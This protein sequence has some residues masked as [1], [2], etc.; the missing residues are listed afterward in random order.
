MAAAV[1]LWVPYQSETTIPS[2]PHSPFSNSPSSHGCSLQYVPFSL[3]YADITDHAPASSTAASNGT[4]EISRNV[5]S[6]T[7]ELIVMRSNSE[8]FA[9]KCFTEQPIPFDCTPV[10]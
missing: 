8:S 6:S 4:S 5:R 10:M 9:T 1:V 3:L 7:S 2:K